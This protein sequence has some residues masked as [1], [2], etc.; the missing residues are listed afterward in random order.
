MCCLQRR[1]RSE[2][3]KIVY[4]MPEI[5]FAAETAFRGLLHRGMPEQELNLLQ[6][7]TTVV[8]Q[9]GT[10]PP[11]VVAGQFALSPL[12]RSRF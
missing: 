9:L 1:V 10:R 12:S 8:A 7:T 3:E 6:F 2:V 4:R 5:L 11:Q